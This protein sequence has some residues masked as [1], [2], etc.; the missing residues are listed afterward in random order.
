MV[1]LKELA[2]ADL[3][4][5]ILVSIPYGTIKRIAYGYVGDK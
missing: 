1:R 5:D 4:I 2:V 3:K